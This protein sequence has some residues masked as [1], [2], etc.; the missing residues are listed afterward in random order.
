MNCFATLYKNR[1]HDIF[2]LLLFSLTQSVITDSATPWIAACQASL[3]F[4]ISQSLLKLTSVES[5]MSSTI[6]S[7]VAPFSS[8]PRQERKR[9]QHQG[10]FPM[11]WLSPQVA[12]V[13][14]VQL[15]HQSFQW[16]FRVDFLRID[17]LNL[18]TVHGTLKSL[19]QHHSLKASVL[20]CSA[21]FMVQPSI[22]T[23]LLEKTIVLTIQTFVGKMMSLSFNMLSGFVIAFLPRSK[24]L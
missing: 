10:F 7:S 14:E 2:F 6:S 21:F 15:Q 24:H 11:S 22:H 13:L 9:P 23:W 12:K 19:L 5:V 16:I 4:T 17:W 8:C 18:L 3:S 1:N 20:W